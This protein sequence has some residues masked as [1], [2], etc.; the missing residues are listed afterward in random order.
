M[1]DHGL[2]IVEAYFVE[3][4]TAPDMTSR[5]LMTAVTPEAVNLF[6][7][8]T[9]QGQ[10]L[11][12]DSLV[13]VAGNIIQLDPNSE[14]LVNLPN[15]LR[16]KR[17]RIVFK[18]KNPSQPNGAVYFYTGYTDFAGW[19]SAHKQFAP[20]MRIYFNNCIQVWQTQRMTQNGYVPHIQV[21]EST[22]LIHPNNLGGGQGMF[23]TQFNGMSP[24][25]QPSTLRPCDLAYAMS[26]NKMQQEMG[27]G[28]SQVLDMRAGIDLVKSSRDNAIPAKYL[29]KT[30]EA[31][32]QGIVESSDRTGTTASTP[33]EI[34]GARS[35]EPTAYGDRFLHPLAADYG[36]QLNGF[37]TWAD[38]LHLHP[39]L[40]ADGVTFVNTLGDAAVR[41]IYRA[42]AGDFDTMVN[43][44]RPA[45][46]MFM[47][48]MQSVPA[49]L[50]Q[51]LITVARVSAT[52][53]TLDGSIQ[54]FVTDPQSF[55][56]LPQGY[57]M[58]KV[59][60][61]QQRL[62]H[63]VFNDMAFSRQAPFDIQLTIEVFGESFGM[64]SYNGE[65]HVPY[66]Q[67]SYADAMFTSLVTPNVNVLASMANDINYLIMSV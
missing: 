23:Q 42:N 33:Y 6:G 28:G 15:G 50:L 53:M 35:E 41:D 19:S 27:L 13:G 61:V 25:Q 59:Q 3:T 40:Q 36:L 5:N 34:A 31:F 8:H 11:H 24:V 12:P 64:I 16:T 46:L 10:Y 56:D 21:N 62:Q 17:F 52:N 66:T 51:N 9:H 29:S 14:R 60:I 63:L 65:P 2:K 57:L 54:V 37:V 20:E 7:H 67:T 32:S 43:D 4:G 39:E 22:H 55:A 38:I 58:E 45:T 30:A 26:S 44:R 49:M 47:Q 48:L 18:V 1:I